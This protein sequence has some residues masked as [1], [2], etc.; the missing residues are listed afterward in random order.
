MKK[1]KHQVLGMLALITQLGVIMIVSILICTLIGN[2]IGQRLDMEWISVLGFFLGAMSGFT[3]V[4][5]TVSRFLNK[6]N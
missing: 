2:W 5:R 1:E 3:G 4:Y 6:K